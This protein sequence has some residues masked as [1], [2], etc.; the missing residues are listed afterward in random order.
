[1]VG[2]RRRAGAAK[3]T[4]FLD[5]SVLVR[6]FTDSPPH[7]ADISA[8]IIESDED[9]VVTDVVIAEA[10]HVLRSFYGAPREMILDRL[11]GLLERDN[12]QV[13]HLD[14]DLVIQA[15]EL[16]RPSNR[17]S[18][19]DA[20]IWAVARSERGATIYTLD[21]RFPGDGVTLKDHL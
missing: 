19:P 13:H 20:L 4:N 3:L 9:L 17:I 11:I 18:V 12:V 1:V 8:E 21:H 16:G 7:L 14:K 6:Y 15:L 5:T 10:A 2:R